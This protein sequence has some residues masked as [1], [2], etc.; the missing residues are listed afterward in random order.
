MGNTLPKLDQVIEIA[1]NN[2]PN[3]THGGIITSSDV[4]HKV[5]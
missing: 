3:T 5:T 4:Y 2:D 1:Y